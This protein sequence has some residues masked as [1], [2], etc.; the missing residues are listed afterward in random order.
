MTT[1]KIEAQL[2]ESN[3]KSALTELRAAG[4]V[5]AVLYGFEAD[6]T[7]IAVKERDVLKAV[8]EVGRN[9]VVELAVDGKSY[10]AVLQDYQTE[11]LRTNLTH[12]DFLS[13]DMTEELE[14]DVIVHP[15]GTSA[16][17]KE[18]GIV[19]QPTRELTI[20]VKP[21]AIPESYDIDI[22]ALEIGDSIS[23]ADIREEAP[24]EILNEDDESLI[25]ISAPRSEEELE[26]LDEVADADASVEPEVIGAADDEEDEE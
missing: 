2:R 16:G 12:A 15:V 24:F 17:E 5:P 19:E 11:V 23:V 9:G 1:V 3:K 22:T 21:T 26:A 25:V 4:F 8:E 14:V 10:N 6:N 7:T 18:G 13:I 20:K